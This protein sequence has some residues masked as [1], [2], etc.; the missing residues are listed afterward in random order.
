LGQGDRPSAQ[1]ANVRTSIERKRNEA[2][3]VKEGDEA[4]PVI[5]LAQ[6]RAAKRKPQPD[7]AEADSKDAGVEVPHPDYRVISRSRA[8]GHQIFHRQGITN[9]PL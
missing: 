3:E 4:A 6:R 7:Q 9:D 8:T 2:A 5:E 1:S